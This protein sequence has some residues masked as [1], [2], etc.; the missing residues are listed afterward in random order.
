VARQLEFAELAAVDGVAVLVDQPVVDEQA[1]D[2]DGVALP[3]QGS[4][5]IAK[6][7]GPHSVSP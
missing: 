3:R 2:A 5:G 7:L 4:A 6:L 1:R